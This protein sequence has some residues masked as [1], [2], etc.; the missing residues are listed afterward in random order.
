MKAILDLGVQ[1]KNALSRGVEQAFMP[2]FFGPEDS[3]FRLR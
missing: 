1:K 3:A 2:A